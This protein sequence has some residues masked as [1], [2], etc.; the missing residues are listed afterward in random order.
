M[1]VSGMIVVMLTLVLLTV[2]PIFL[3]QKYGNFLGFKLV[4]SPRWKG[5]LIMPP[6][7][8]GV[9]YTIFFTFFSSAYA[10]L[11]MTEIFKPGYNWLGVITDAFLFLTV[12]YFCTIPL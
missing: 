1:F 2:V 10:Y 11:W 5:G 4:E 9:L 8:I 12:L 3:A 6:K 7:W